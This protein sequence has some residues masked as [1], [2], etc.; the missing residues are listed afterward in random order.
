MSK[1]FRG[2]EEE[3]GGETSVFALREFNSDVESPLSLRQQR[4]SATRLQARCPHC[5]SIIY[6]R[7]HKLCGVCNEHLPESCLFDDLQARNVEETMQEDRRKHRAWLKKAAPQKW[8]SA[9][10]L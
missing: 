8:Q 5:N 3:A 9:A 7:R 6:S 1:W 10:Y 2:L 4:L